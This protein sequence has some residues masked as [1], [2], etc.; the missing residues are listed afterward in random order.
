MTTQKTL[1]VDLDDTICIPNH[2]EKDT[3]RKYGL[4]KPIPEMIEA[5]KAARK[6]DYKIVISTA[7]RMLTH[8]GDINKVIEDVDEI[9]TTWL[10][11]FEVP[12]DE[13]QYGK[14][15]GVYYI[16]DK[17]MLPYSFIEL[18]KD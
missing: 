7:R 18:M 16:D 3:Y 5:L 4:A 8:R 6:R 9:T 2:D 14:P 10:N 17:A 12:Y 1:V 11:E 15:Y 13:I